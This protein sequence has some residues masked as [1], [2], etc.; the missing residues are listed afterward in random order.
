MK[1][2]HIY[3]EGAKVLHNRCVEIAN[4]Y[5]VLIETGSTFNN[6]IGTSITSISQIEKSTVKSIVK[7]DD[8]CL[9]TLEKENYNS[10]MFYNITNELLKNNISISTLINNSAQNLEISFTI[11]SV[12]FAKFEYLMKN[13]LNKFKFSYTDISKISIVGYGIANN[14]DI[15]EDILKIFNLNNTEILTIQ[16]SESKISIITKEKA[17]D[18]L[19]TELHQEL[20]FLGTEQKNINK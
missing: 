2:C 12:D 1:K 5:N 7:N 14:I 11:K 15:I 6:N 3:N 8:I 18:K 9:I 19:L 16:I 10:E 20:M 13:N 4:K 17:L